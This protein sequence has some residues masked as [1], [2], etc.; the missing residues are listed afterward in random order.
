M[1]DLIKLVE[2]KGFGKT[3]SAE[4]RRLKINGATIHGIAANRDFV[5]VA[6]NRAKYLSVFDNKG[7][8][9]NSSR[10]QNVD[11]REKYPSRINFSGVSANKENVV[12]SDRANPFIYK[13]DCEGNLVNVIDSYYP[14]E[15]IKISEDGRIFTASWEGCCPSELYDIRL[16]NK[17]SSRLE[18]KA[19]NIV[20]DSSG[21]V[22]GLDYETIFDLIVP[23]I[24]FKPVAG[25]E[26]ITDAAFDTKYF[27]VA[28]RKAEWSYFGKYIKIFLRDVNP[29]FLNSF[30]LDTQEANANKLALVDNNLYVQKGFREVIKLKIIKDEGIDDCVLREESVSLGCAA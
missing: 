14:S 28:T 16:F 5:F 23:E 2:D 22:Y 17:G 1:S 19:K 9:M 4:Y 10:P 6:D 26:W 11:L 20:L 24:K 21:I 25:E 15:H 29:V 12:A 27:F 30:M 7:N 18:G 13:Y 3:F 8:F